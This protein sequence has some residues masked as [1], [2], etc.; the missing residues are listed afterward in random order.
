MKVKIELNSSCN[1]EFTA[2]PKDIIQ[3]FHDA[4]FDQQEHCSKSVPYHQELILMDYIKN[5]NLNEL[6]MMFH[7]LS[8]QDFYMGQL[9]KDPLRQAKYSAISGIT[10]ITRSAIQGGLPE[11]EA[12]NLSDVYI[13][14]LDIMNDVN[15]VH[16]LLFTAACDFTKR[17]QL[18]K[19]QATLY[20]HTITLCIEYIKCHLHYPITLQDLAKECQ[21]SP[22]YLST[23]FKKETGKTITAYIMEEKLET[24]KQM[25]TNH[26][27][28]LSEIAN[29]LGF[30]SHSNFTEHFHKKYGITPRAYRNRIK[31]S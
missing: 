30:C 8:T 5:G 26:S 20:S 3:A 19:D 21:L 15:D 13:Q 4:M 31:L 24:A 22:P 27:Y 12:Y 2:P 11:I 6:R 14:K 16:L 17:V 29:Y 1:P 25:L 18:K 9:S 7:T 10:L 28:T 23:L